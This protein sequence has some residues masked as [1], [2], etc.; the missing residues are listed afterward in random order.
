MPT[1]PSAQAKLSP[2]TPAEIA[3]HLPRPLYVAP[4]L[5]SMIRP[6]PVWQNAAPVGW[7]RRLTLTPVPGRQGAWY[8]AP[9]RVDAKLLAGVRATY[10]VP[11]T[12]PTAEATEAA[13]SDV[14]FL[15]PPLPPMSSPDAG[16][17]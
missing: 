16:A 3:K 9:V 7:E 10:A 15:V 14:A 1:P 17:N 4:R 6:H 5:D 13:K 11:S 2:S 8:I 12:F